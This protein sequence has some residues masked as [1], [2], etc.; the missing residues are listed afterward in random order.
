MPF[1]YGFYYS[2]IPRPLPD[3]ILQL[4]RRSSGIIATSRAGNG[5]LGQYVIWTRFVLTESTISSP[6]CSNDPRPSPN[7]TSRNHGCEIKSGSGL[8]IKLIFPTQFVNTMLHI[9]VIWVMVCYCVLACKCLNRCYTITS[10]MISFILQS[11]SNS[12][13]NYQ[14][15]DSSGRNATTV[16]LRLTDDQRMS[17]VQVVA[18]DDTKLEWPRNFT[19]KIEDIG[20][21]SLNVIDPNEVTVVITDNDGEFQNWHNH[22]CN[23]WEGKSMLTQWLWIYAKHYLASVGW[24]GVT[25]LPTVIDTA[26]FRAYITRWMQDIGGAGEP[27]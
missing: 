27:E 4:W 2:L 25:I 26:R 12:T 20:A 1:Q 19:V 16:Y 5:G 17:C 13:G 18:V 10:V 24:E 6:W 8:G 23:W 21:N 9:C 22:T 7:V 14:L 11:S 15:L 3:F